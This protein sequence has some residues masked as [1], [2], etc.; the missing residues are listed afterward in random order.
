VYAPD[1]LIWDTGWDAARALEQLA[2]TRE[3]AP[4]ILALLADAGRAADALSAGARGVLLQETDPEVLAAALAAAARGLTVLAPDLMP[5]PLL[6][7]AD[8]IVAATESLTPREVEVLSLLAEGL[9]NKN[10][11]SRLGISEHTVKFHV[12]A[13]MNKLGAQSRTEAVVRATRLGMIVL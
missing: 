5:S 13:V 7:P 1:V 10:I 6:A 4:P 8:D 11:A 9:P 12:N 3:A 2:V